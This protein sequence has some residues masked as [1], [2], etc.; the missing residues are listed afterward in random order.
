ML[1]KARFVH[2]G[3]PLYESITIFLSECL[4]SDIPLYDCNPRPSTFPIKIYIKCRYIEVGCDISVCYKCFA[5]LY[6]KHG[7][8]KSLW[9]VHTVLNIHEY[10]HDIYKM[11]KMSIHAHPLSCFNSGKSHTSILAKSCYDCLVPC[12]RMPLCVFMGA[13]LLCEGCN[14]CAPPPPHPPLN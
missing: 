6:T 12:G 1:I 9:F 8:V 11:H 13:R 14:L 2:K 4:L 5:I 10:E 7:C 3:H